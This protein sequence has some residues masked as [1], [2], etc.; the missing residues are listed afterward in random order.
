MITRHIRHRD[1]V[2][3]F[4]NQPST[5]KVSEVNLMEIKNKLRRRT[6]LGQAIV[7]GV[8]STL[9]ITSTAHGNDEK[10]CEERP[11]ADLLLLFM[12]LLFDVQGKVF[13][14]A[15]RATFQ[16]AR[17]CE[18]TLCEL[19]KK[20]EELKA[21]ICQSPTSKRAE[22]MRDLVEAGRINAQLLE[23]I[24]GASEAKF[25]SLTAALNTINSLVENAAK[26][27]QTECKF[28][29]TEKGKR[30]LLDIIEL[31]EKNSWICTKITA[32]QKTFAEDVDV[33]RCRVRTVQHYI[34]DAAEA[35]AHKNFEKF[36]QSIDN[37]ITML[38]TLDSSV[39]DQ[40]VNT[41]APVEPLDRSKTGK[42]TDPIDSSKTD[43]ADT[44]M[45][46]S[47]CMPEKVSPLPPGN[48]AEI[49]I[50]LLRGTQELF[51]NPE[52]RPKV[53]RNQDPG[54]D[55][56]RALF[57]TVAAH[58]SRERT[59]SNSKP[60][61]AEDIGT[62]LGK[63]C[64][65][66]SYYRRAKLTLAVDVAWTI[67]RNDS[68]KRLEAIWWTILKLGCPAGSDPGALAKELA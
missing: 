37:A 23:K 27:V 6:F 22:Q 15:A 38:L 48:P 28:V 19:S 51:K 29:L 40:R 25:A 35:A 67:Y 26:E 21:E 31:I 13:Y 32:S 45:G 14:K 50:G 11:F 10:T 7:G 63:Y 62:L 34:F 68:E 20:I 9:I 4:G 65:P 16:P 66:Y 43:S 41:A 59:S 5:H 53:T 2:L 36:D 33:G 54:A 47:D 56:K 57:K 64:K 46:A 24:S 44:S 30:L 60:L 8:A 3:V 18:K 1:Q 58:S 39:K 61:L 55:E 17:D 52:A 12:E 42:E 49:L